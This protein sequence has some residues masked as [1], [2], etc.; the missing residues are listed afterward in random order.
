MVERELLR[1]F[2]HSEDFD[3]ASSGHGVY[4]FQYCPRFETRSSKTFDSELDCFW[5]KYADFHLKKEI[6]LDVGICCYPHKQIY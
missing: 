2:E 3:E 5:C 6:C 1:N 4:P